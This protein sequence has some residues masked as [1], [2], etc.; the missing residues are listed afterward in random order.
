M[1]KDL[2]LDQGF[3]FKCNKTTTLIVL[4]TWEHMGELR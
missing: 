4:F 1:L 3:V 2:D